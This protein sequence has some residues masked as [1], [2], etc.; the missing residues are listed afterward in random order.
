MKGGWI[1]AT[2]PFPKSISPEAGGPHVERCINQ[3]HGWDSGIKS[4]LDSQGKSRCSQ[5]ARR[6]D[7]PLRGKVTIR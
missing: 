6:E 5:V 7:K 2:D 1:L 3:V 4:M